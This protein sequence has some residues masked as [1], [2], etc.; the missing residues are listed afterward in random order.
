MCMHSSRFS[1]KPLP[2]RYVE[3]AGTA[4]HNGLK[5][6]LRFDVFHWFYLVSS[7]GAGK[8]RPCRYKCSLAVNKKEVPLAPI[9]SILISLNDESDLMVFCYIFQ[10][11][12][13]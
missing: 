1:F 13:S 4:P 7:F 6:S 12:R 10:S 3:Y 9:A 11:L 8:M 5:C 2:Q